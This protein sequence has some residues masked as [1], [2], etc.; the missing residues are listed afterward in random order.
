MT[1]PEIGR[2]V[3]QRAAARKRL[4]GIGGAA[5][6]RPPAPNVSAAQSSAGWARSYARRLMITDTLV[7]LMSGLAVHLVRWGDVDA[8]VRLSGQA[9]VW[10]VLGL[11]LLIV[12]AWLTALAAAGTRRPPV[13]GFGA[14]EYK[15]VAR[16]TLAV[17][18]GLAILSYLLGLRLPRSYLVLMLPIGLLAVLASRYLWRRWLHKRR[19]FG[20]YQSRVVA[21]G[22][23]ATVADLVHDLQRSPR[24]GFRVVAVCLTDPE[25]GADNL[26][27]A[28]LPIM[29][30]VGDV[31]AAVRSCGADTV[32]V[33]ATDEVGPAAVRNLSWQLEDIDDVDC[34]LV[35]AP[36]LTDIAGPRV[37]TQPVNG[38]PLIHV[39]RPTYRGANR[40]LK[41]TF[42]VV[43]ASVLLVLL[44]PPLLVI[45]AVVKLTSRGPVF[46]RQP[47]VGLNGGTFGMIKFRS[48]VTNAEELLPELQRRRDE[49]A[50]AA[51]NSVMFKL[52]DDPRITKAGKWLRRFSLDE[53][54][55]L[56][57]VLGGS[58]SLVGPRPPLP[59][60]VAKYEN[61]VHRRLLVKPGMTGLWQVSG[62]SRLSWEETVRLDSYY[63]ENWSMTGDL[64][65]LWKTA[66]AVVGRDG[67]Y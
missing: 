22:S 9:G 52:V 54:P 25:R 37:H 2:P 38:L 19:D 18:G 13:V 62:R 30:G 23:T 58:M 4:A 27:L 50:A 67:A 3:V 61:H 64:Q 26:A 29:G 55:Q 12:A 32:A 39:D 33:T 60:E 49:A 6:E 40:L 48:M 20:H 28:G 35:L 11:T 15:R 10:P 34:S 51:G 59:E 46:F 65:I 24:A 5:V 14:T 1:A 42:D 21:V 17:F 53:L 57:N 7:L 66:R 8:A 31:A 41:K 43:G 45:A 56:L 63:V 36:A 47:R 16:A 44:S